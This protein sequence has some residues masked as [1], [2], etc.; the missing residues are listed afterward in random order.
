M[1]YCCTCA[2]HLSAA[3]SRSTPSIKAEDRDLQCC[4]RIIC[5]GCLENNERF[6]TYCPYCQISTR[7]TA[8][9]QGLRDPPSYASIS[10]RRPPRSEMADAPPAYTSSAAPTPTTA[11]QDE[12]AALAAADKGV[13]QDTLHFLD[14]EHDTI[15]S[16]ALRYNVPVS[17]L[18]RTNKITSDHLLLGRRTVLIPGEF[19]KGGV[20]L[21]PRPIEGEEEELR[22]NK[23]RRFMTSC[24]VA[25]YDVAQL[26]LEQTSY[27]LDAAVDAY[28]ADEAWEREQS[29]SNEGG[30]KTGKNRGPFWRGL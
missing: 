22:K 24:K 7:P 10:A 29:S 15:A 5:G 25:D 2:T 28:L 12:K 26:Y 6:A 23:I 13:V 1:D 30:K 3:S 16:L 18:R 4:G 21:S 14:H 11:A 8:L 9:P 27:D 17:A 19:Y 20:S